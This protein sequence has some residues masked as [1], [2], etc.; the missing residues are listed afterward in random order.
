MING[1]IYIMFAWQGKKYVS[2]EMRM[3]IFTIFAVLALAGCISLL[4]LRGRCCGPEI[5]EEKPSNKKTAKEGFLEFLITIKRTFRLLFTEN[6]ALFAPYIIYGGFYFGFLS[7]V[8]PTVVGNSK[9][10]EDSS[11]QVGFTGL[12]TGIGGF[13]SS[14]VFIFGSKFFDKF[15]RSRIAIRFDLRFSCFSSLFSFLFLHLIAYVLTAIN[16]PH[17]ANYQSTENLPDW[18]L[19]GSSNLSIALLI[20]FL[21][22]FGDGGLKNVL[23]SS[24]TEG[25]PIE[26]T[27]AFALKQVE[28]H[29]I[30][31]SKILSS[32]M[33]FQAPFVS[34]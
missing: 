17:D 9:N 34:S 25:F 24:I 29:K 30:L 33:L 21:L 1:N 2:S 26:T 3:T 14:A 32:W 4:F 27:S 10:L 12:L 8:Y 16:F 31:I 23:F 11:A 18:N 7:G 22:G 19:F 5:T 13:I 15:S 20:A 6:M 28:K